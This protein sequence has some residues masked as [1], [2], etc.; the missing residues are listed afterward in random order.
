MCDCLLADLACATWE[1]VASCIHKPLATNAHAPGN[2][3][4]PQL[5]VLYNGTSVWILKLNSL[6]N[7][8]VL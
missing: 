3:Q 1:L 4:T 7:Y 5:T 2:T 6:A 8:V